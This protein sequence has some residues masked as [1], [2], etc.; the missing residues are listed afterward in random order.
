[1]CVDTHQPLLNGPKKICFDFYCI[2]SSCMD[3]YNDIFK[4]LFETFP[5]K[6]CLRVLDE[7]CHAEKLQIENHKTKTGFS[8]NTPHDFRKNWVK[9]TFV[10][11]KMRLH[12]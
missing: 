9:T 7:C 1:M 2:F 3:N 10:L 4:F 12:I 6:C 11:L 5:K 8:M